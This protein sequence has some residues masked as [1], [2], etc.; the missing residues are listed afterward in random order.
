MARPSKL[1]P[2]LQA[3]ICEHLE[4]GN[5]LETA[6]AAV[7][8]H[9]S[10]VYDWMDKGADEEEGPHADF[11]AAVDLARALAEIHDVAQVRARV[12]NW[13]AHM[14]L[15]ERRS[16]DRWGRKQRIDHAGHDGGP[17]EIRLAY[18]SDE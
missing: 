16:P 8:V 10:T 11:L 18:S 13:Q 9:K 3:E 2:E 17:V 4:A 15:L 6:A 1:T 5:Y 7:G 12:D 14:T